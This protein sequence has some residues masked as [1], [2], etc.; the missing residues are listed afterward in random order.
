MFTNIYKKLVID[1]SKITLFFIFILLS[2]SIYHAKN[3][4]LDASSD[5]LILEG[6]KDLK[7]FIIGTR[8]LQ[9]RNEKLNESL[10]FFSIMFFENVLVT[11]SLPGLGECFPKYYK[12]FHGA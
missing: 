10:S 1:F 7:Y 3:F 6:D 12:V 4:N 5:A 2:F 11:K 8:N 9:S